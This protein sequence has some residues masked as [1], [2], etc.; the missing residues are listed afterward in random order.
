LD[1]GNDTAQVHDL[2]SGPGGTAPSLNNITA[3]D[4]AGN[5]QDYF[6]TI[7]LN[8]GSISATTGG[9]FDIVQTFDGVAVA[10]LSVNTGS[11]T[12]SVFVGDT[13]AGSASI[14]TGDNNDFLQFENDEFGN[15]LVD[16]GKGD[17]NANFNNVGVASSINVKLGDGNDY[18]RCEMVFAG[19]GVVDGGS[20][21]DVFE[22]GGGNAGFSVVN[23]EG[24][25]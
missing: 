20:G 3:T 11:T 9:G 18:I 22:D 19:F 16:T 12:D 23:F 15:L 21:T 25:I 5:D 14:L 13:Q 10:S 8:T 17:D 6:F 24:F 1:K 7:T 4:D 2:S